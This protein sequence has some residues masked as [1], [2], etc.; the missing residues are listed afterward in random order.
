TTKLHYV[1]F[2][3]STFFNTKWGRFKPHEEHEDSPLDLRESLR[4]IKLAY[5]NH[6]DIL[7]YLKFYSEENKIIFKSSKHIKEI[8][9][10]DRF[11]LLYNYFTGF[12]VSPL[13]SMFALF[14]WSFS[15]FCVFVFFYNLEFNAVNFLSLIEIT[16]PKDSEA[17]ILFNE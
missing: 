11:I 1:D 17:N 6:S 7:N 4:T 3:K 12:G 8:N 10:V 13:K 14:V 2:S 16:S 5:K 15:H 9:W